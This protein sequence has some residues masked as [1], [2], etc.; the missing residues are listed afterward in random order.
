MNIAVL[1]THLC[2]I[3][4]YCRL[5]YMAKSDE[6]NTRDEQNEGYIAHLVERQFSVLEETSAAIDKKAATLLGFVAI[7]VT[8]VLQLPS[9][10][11]AFHL[12]TLLF[13]VAFALLLGSLFLLILCI[14]P[15]Q[16]RFDPNPV[17]LLKK[18]WRSS[19]KET[20]EQVTKNLADVWAENYAV[21]GKKAKLLEWAL[22]LVITG[23]F[24]LAFDILIIRVFENG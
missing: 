3:K 2:G 17:V 5:R 11:P 10:G 6:G 7:I 21:H 16:K 23:L 18:Y 19:L 8:L 15:R 14:A 4:Q 13:Y 24:I 20:R 12:D 22:R 9:P 1:A